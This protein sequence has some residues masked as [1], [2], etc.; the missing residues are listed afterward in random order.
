MHKNN[1]RESVRVTKLTTAKSNAER[2]ERPTHIVVKYE[3]FTTSQI[4]CK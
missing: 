4:V 1:Q 2:E 3:I